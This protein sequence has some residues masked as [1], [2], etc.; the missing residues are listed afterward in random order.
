MSIGIKRKK[1]TNNIHNFNDMSYNIRNFKEGDMDLTM[2]Q[3]IDKSSMKDDFLGKKEKERDI[4]N[5]QEKMAG[6]FYRINE[7]SGSIRYIGNFQLKENEEHVSYNADVYNFNYNF[8]GNNIGE[9]NIFCSHENRRED[10][11]FIGR[12]EISE[13]EFREI[14]T[15]FYSEILPKINVVQ[16]AK[17]ISKNPKKSYEIDFY[18][19]TPLFNN[20]DPS[21]LGMKVSD[22]IKKIEKRQAEERGKCG[23]LLNQWVYDYKHANFQ[24]LLS[25][26]SSGECK[27]IL[28]HSKGEG[29]LISTDTIL[30]NYHSVFCDVDEDDTD[31]LEEIINAV[32]LI[33]TN[34][35]EGKETK[36]EPESVKEQKIIEAIRKATNGTFIGDYYSSTSMGWSKIYDEEGRLLTA[37]PNYMDSSINING[38]EYSLTRKGWWAYIWNPESKGNYMVL[39]DKNNLEESLL[40]KVDLRPDYVKEY[41]KRQEQEKVS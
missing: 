15:L 40:A 22:I 6:K 2:Q 17:K 25:I 18:N 5:F 10:I 23:P 34:V 36:I 24:K 16:N 21:Y 37:D 13:E 26:D 27:A 39:L 28:L 3:Y 19:L 31:R 4:E 1:I 30:H 32:S 41:E 20:D 29:I 12:T 9:K 14:E 38:T 11:D 8:F 33:V 7:Y 35:V